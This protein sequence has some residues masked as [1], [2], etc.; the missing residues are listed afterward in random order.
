MGAP[1][2]RFLPIFPLLLLPLL[3]DCGQ[4]TQTASLS[5]TVDP[6]GADLRLDGRY[7]GR[8][9]LSGWKVSPGRHRLEVARAG[10]YPHSV[11]LEIIGET[12]YH[13]VILPRTAV[14]A[15]RIL[16]PPAQVWVDGAPILLQTN[17]EFAIGPHELIAWAPWYGLH[18]KAFSV[19]ADRDQILTL[20]LPRHAQSAD[21]FVESDPPGA[22]LIFEGLPWAA[23]PQWFTGLDPE[24][25][26]TLEARVH[27]FEEERL[28]V[29]LRAREKRAL[30]FVFRRNL[31]EP[32][33]LL[34]VPRDATLVFERFPSGQALLTRQS[35]AEGPVFL[36]PGNYRVRLRA[37]G[38][39]DL[40]SRFEVLTNM[41]ASL[42]LDPVARF[43]FK[44]AGRVALPGGEWGWV[45]SIAVD[46][47]GLYVSDGKLEKVFQVDGGKILRQWDTPGGIRCL[48]AEGGR[49][50]ALGPNGILMLRGAEAS[51]P[52]EASNAL[53]VLAVSGGNL[54]MVE[55]GARI[56][57]RQGALHRDFW[58]LPE[59]AS[60]QR[61]PVQL[62]AD[63]DLCVAADA[64]SRQIWWL[65]T[66]GATNAPRAFRPAGL[67]RPG[68]IALA[69]GVVL[70]SDGE[71]KSILVLDRNRDLL[72]TVAL[73]GSM[74]TPGILAADGKSLWVVE[75]GKEIRRYE[76]VRQGAP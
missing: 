72:A 63:G 52:I 19:K 35:G 42:A 48:A 38:Y 11:D 4:K 32:I 30:R 61:N 59:L 43:T 47:Q 75:G 62:A 49:L 56:W 1:V 54:W 3:T 57:V 26:W 20:D 73:P 15:F 51:L 13:A 31:R 67:L 68:G 17:Q 44:D 24:K 16:P 23:A 22:Q 65:Q 41:P 21:L 36:P 58:P 53:P 66:T 45:R 70:V 40:S 71:S 74:G 9:P 76:M 50:W 55:A 5:V 12:R 6:A 14:V 34:G 25:S 7:V 28:T 27:G 33:H 39:W 64:G 2:T 29:K 8:S 46:A 60:V 37:P 10:F 18:R 69:P